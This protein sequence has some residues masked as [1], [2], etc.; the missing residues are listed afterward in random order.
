MIYSRRILEIVH[1]QIATWPVVILEGPRTVGK[2]TL[3]RE[4]ASSSGVDIVDLDEPD[5]KDRVEADPQAF[6]DRTRRPVLID[7]YP[8]VPSLIR[9]IKAQLNRDGSPGRFVLTGSA[10]LEA[11]R[12]D[13]D[14]LVGRYGDVMILPLS[15]S[16]I[17]GR[18]GHFVEQVFGDVEKLR[19][20]RPSNTDRLSY[21][22]KVLIGGFPLVVNSLDPTDRYHRFTN[23]IDQ[24][25]NYG[26]VNLRAIREREYL[27]RLLYRCAAQTGQLLNIRNAARDVGL[28]RGTA[29][30]YM[31]LLET[32]FLVHR[33]PAWKATDQG[34]VS[35]PKLYV[36]DSGVAGRL[37]RLTE[38]KM[39]SGEPT[40]LNQYGHL[41]ETFVLGEIRKM[42][43]WMDGPS[44]IGYWRNRR[45]DEVD[46]VVERPDDG[47]VIGIEVKAGARVASRDWKGLRMFREETRS[48]FRAGLVMYTGD[49]P[50]RLDEGIYAMPIDKL[51][52]GPPQPAGHS[53]GAGVRRR[54]GTTT[55]SA[56]KAG[57]GVLT[58]DGD[59][60]PEPLRAA[61]GKMIDRMRI[62]E[63]SYW[64][65]AVVPSEHVH[66][67]D[68]YTGDGVAGA[69]HEFPA[70]SG[71]DVEPIDQCA[72]AVHRPRR[73][74]LGHQVPGLG[75]LVHP[76]GSMAF[77]TAAVDHPPQTRW[78]LISR[79]SEDLI[80]FARQVLSPH[81]V[82]WTYW[83]AGRRLRTGRPIFSSVTSEAFENQPAK[84]VV[85]DPPHKG[86]P[87]A[88]D[89]ASEAFLLAT[90]F[91]EWFGIPA[92][93]LARIADLPTRR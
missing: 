14:A 76:L 5:V 52:E 92:R 62:G 73:S 74:A 83:S 77:V 30:N 21:I 23:Y 85:N 68:F 72:T 79:W 9:H 45:G 53:R 75:A 61:T 80:R 15:Q 64:E 10:S 20:S 66:F 90:T 1:R 93:D 47:A 65:V 84:A 24:S 33:L 7:E 11:N 26:M 36:V 27:L 51:W 18:G 22:R 3:L 57:A 31:R 19:S 37:L 8:K 44:T 69:L 82:S 58:A 59:P 32:L 38:E 17:E 56:P 34:P 39:R 48:R 46:L 86:I 54:T 55:T 71:G 70:W 28:K 16:E 42:L 63:A 6:V 50:Y 41:L 13:L 25:I 87:M 4:I 35:R 2:S 89:Q 12:P 78:P 49:T 88:D 60:L 91:Y 43:S 67:G 40:F 81:A 29:E